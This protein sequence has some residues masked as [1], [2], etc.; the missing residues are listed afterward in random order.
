MKT[1]RLLVILAIFSLIAPLA[2][3]ADYRYYKPLS[4]NCDTDAAAKQIPQ[5]N[6][7][8]STVCSNFDYSRISGDKYR[9]VFKLV[10]KGPQDDITKN[11]PLP[12]NNVTNRS[13]A[14]QKVVY[15]VCAGRYSIR[16]DAERH[17]ATLRQFGY[18][19]KLNISSRNTYRVVLGKTD[20]SPKAAKLKSSFEKEG[21]SCFIEEE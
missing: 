12:H 5:R 1:S 14:K 16:A 19:S 4:K 15:L 8:L 3:G 21:V 9:P 11:S 13:D 7:P 20:N 10:F 17:V 6:L 2:I 18:S